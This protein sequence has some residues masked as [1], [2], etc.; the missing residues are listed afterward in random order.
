MPR[1]RREADHR[2]GARA[3]GVPAAEAA[4]SPDRPRIEAWVRNPIDAFILARLEENGLR[5]APEADRAT[6]IRRLSFDL[7]GLPPT[8]E[9]VDAFLDDDSPDAYERLVDR[10][11]ASPQYGERWAQHWLDLARY[12]DTDG[13][14]F[15]Q[16]RPDAWRYRDWVVDAPEPRHALRP[17]SSASSSP[18]TRSHPTIPRRSSP[19]GSTAAIPTWST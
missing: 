19:P 16:A 17:S 1:D 7:T 6:L 4:A 11:L 10:L 18:A 15:D 5:P 9:E 13:F 14:E 12:A 2:R 8:P 3:L